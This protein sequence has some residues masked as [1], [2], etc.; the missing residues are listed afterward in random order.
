MGRRS[1]KAIRLLIS[2]AYLTEENKVRVGNLQGTLFD[3]RS[4]S[5]MKIGKKIKNRMRYEIFRPLTAP[6]IESDVN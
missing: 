1:V 3:S 5:G 6:K 4:R 2:S